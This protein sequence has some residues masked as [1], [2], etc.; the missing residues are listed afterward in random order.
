MFAILLDEPLLN[1]LERR[2]LKK[3]SRGRTTVPCC[4]S[5][6]QERMRWRKDKRA[7]IKGHG[8]GTRGGIGQ[9]GGGGGS[10]DSVCHWADR[11][12]SW[13]LSSSVEQCQE[14]R[15]AKGQPA[16]QWERV[17]STNQ[18]WRNKNKHSISPYMRQREA[19]KTFPVKL[20]L[21]SRQRTGLW[22]P[23]FN[24][25]HP[26]GFVGSPR[27]ALFHLLS[28]LSGILRPSEVPML[29]SEADRLLPGICLPARP[30]MCTSAAARARIPCMAEHRKAAR[31]QRRPQGNRPACED[32]I[33]SSSCI[34]AGTWNRCM[35]CRQRRAWRRREK[36][37]GAVHFT[38]IKL[39]A[40]TLKA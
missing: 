27:L 10:W 11:W 1:Y 2:G 24:T 14:A 5:A 31:E 8:R 13:K 19:V 12:G 36:K 16:G 3:A 23:E 40:S 7:M 9:W 39:P 38:E 28:L 29:L 17:W 4:R 22:P 30:A 21:F 33:G 37:H 20:L 35:N 34:T 26:N 18:N 25:S 15:K 32:A 6:K